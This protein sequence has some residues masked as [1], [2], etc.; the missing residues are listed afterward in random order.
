MAQF[1]VYCNPSPVSRDGVPYLVDMQSELLSGLPTR[2]MVPLGKPEVAPSKCPRSLC[3]EVRVDGQPL[4]V[5]PHLAA[6]FRSRD[7]GRPLASLT[8]ESSALVAALD[9]VLSGI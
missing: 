6:A 9:A 5:L 2:L 7:L 4:R 3:P 8:A 1:D